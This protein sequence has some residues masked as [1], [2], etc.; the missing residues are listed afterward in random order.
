M[1][2]E[3]LECPFGHE[4]IEQGELDSEG[5][6]SYLILKNP[7]IRKIYTRNF[8]IILGCDNAS[9]DWYYKDISDLQ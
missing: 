7:D 6:A 2:F 8:H 4:L 9:C 3:S 5:E 1:N